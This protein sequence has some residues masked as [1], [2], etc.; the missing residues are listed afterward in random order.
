MP[1]A[2]LISLGVIW[3]F[4]FVLIRVSLEAFTVEQTE[5]LRLALGTMGL[6]TA[7]C[8]TRTQRGRIPAVSLA[9]LLP[10]IEL[11]VLASVGPYLL[12]AWGER[13]V[14]PAVA[15]IAVASTP[16]WTYLLAAAKR[17]SPSPFSLR[18]SLALA[19]GLVG[20]ALLFRPWTAASTGKSIL[21]TGACL[22][23]AFC[24]AIYY[25]R[26]G[27]VLAA[28]SSSLL[29]LSALQLAIAT[30]IMALVVGL[31]STT[32]AA[33]SPSVAIAVVALGVVCTG[34]AYVVNF[35]VIRNLGFVRAASVNYIHPV[36]TVLVAIPILAQTPPPAFLFS[37]A[38]TLTG[39]WLLVGSPANPRSST[40]H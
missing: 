1:V 6:G 23:A 16:V 38:L 14:A 26:A 22:L 17:D 18:P 30:A 8:F 25:I 40:D 20:V 7:L 13:H 10:L 24:Y 31:S 36:V 15:S 19:M 39:V 21:G 32:W 35:Y 11:A 34:L 9:T 3:G 28:Q 4:S 37:V 29:W 33:P 2:A 12:L 5:F 27:R